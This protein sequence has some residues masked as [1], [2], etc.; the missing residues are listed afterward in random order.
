MASHFK[1]YEYKGV[2]YRARNKEHLVNKL[3]KARRNRRGHYSVRYMDHIL[4]DIVRV[5]KES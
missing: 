1:Q 2:V 5:K 3:F 4:R